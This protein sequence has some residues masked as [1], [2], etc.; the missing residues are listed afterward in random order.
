MIKEALA[1][2]FEGNNLT[3]DEMRAIMDELMT[4]EADPVLA[5]GFLTALSMKGETIDEITAA[6]DGMKAHAV[7]LEHDMDVLEIVGTGGDR[8]NSFNISTTSAFVISAAGIPV[9]KHGNRAAS[10]KSGAADVLEALGM[11]LMLDT[12]K[13]LKAL[14]E[15]GM[16]FMFAQKYH[17]AMRFVGP[18]RAK[19]GIRTVF[20]VL[21]PLT[22]PANANMQVLGVYK[23]ELVEPMAHILHNLGVKKAMVVYGTDGLDEISASAPTK[24]CEMRNGEYKTYEI[25]PEQYGMASCKKEELVGGTGEENAKIAKDILSGK[26]QGAKRNAVLLNAAAGIYIASDTITYEEAVKQ[27]EKLIDSGKAIE[28]LEKVISMTKE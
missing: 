18:I 19:L 10:S 24:V 8:S 11:N 22:N 12:D 28:Q 27:A 25:T 21:G 17:P 4:G 14:K 15:A 13:N 1:K 2:V 6:A 16:C 7:S 20:N 26:E 23:E 9:A 3:Y 5:A